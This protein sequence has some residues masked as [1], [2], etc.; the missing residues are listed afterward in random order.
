MT[1]LL[2]SFMF[3]IACAAAAAAAGRRVGRR[4]AGGDRHERRRCAP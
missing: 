2:V 4:P 1:H 3:Q